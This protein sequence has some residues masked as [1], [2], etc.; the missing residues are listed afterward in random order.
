MK[1]CSNIPGMA[2]FIGPLRPI[3]KWN[4]SPLGRNG[5]TRTMTGGEHWEH[6]F[7][8]GFQCYG[9]C[10]N[11]DQHLDAPQRIPGGSMK[12]YIDLTDN[13]EL[14]LFPTTARRY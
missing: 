7:Q 13:P 12:S 1:N 2:E 11:V 6:R 8:P 14:C 3:W 5:D 9:T 4:E 10:I